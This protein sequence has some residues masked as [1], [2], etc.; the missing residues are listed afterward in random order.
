MCI[1]C[2]GGTFD[3]VVAHIGSAVE[4]DG[5]TIVPVG[6]EPEWPSWA[7]TIRLVDHDHPELV[8]TDQD[9]EV[10]VETLDHLARRVCAGERFNSV[11]STRCQ[12]APGLGFDVGFV[13]VHPAHVDHGV[14][15]LWLVYYGRP[16]PDAVSEPRL[17]QVVLPDVAHCHVHQRTQPLLDTATD[18]LH[19][20]LANRAARRAERRAPRRRRGH[21][22]GRA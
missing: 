15:T 10:G 17:R 18:V 22:R 1:I 16:G 7:S 8:V 3:D 6:G 11:A 2:N 5:W 19:A 9:L 14:V 13:D 4:R 12:W 21:G 20:P